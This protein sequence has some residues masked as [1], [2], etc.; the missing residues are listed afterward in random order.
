MITSSFYEMS[1]E[2]I[3]ECI[4]N[5]NSDGVDFIMEKYKNL[6]RQKARTLFLIGGDKDDLIQEGMIGLY[7]AVR[8]FD[9]SKESSFFH[10]ADLCIT[11]QLYNA[12]K[13]SL[14]QKNIP[15]N[16]Y[17]SIYTPLYKEFA[18]EE[19]STPLMETILPEQKLNPEEIVIDKENTDMI[20]YEL[21]KRLSQ[22]E[23]EVLGFYISGLNYQQIAKKLDK[24]PKSIDNAIQRIKSKLAQLLSSLQ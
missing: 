2:Q 24:S 4:K 13:A 5:G 20:E 16:T 22:F 14:R 8:D 21:G 12:V 18:E 6:V 19:D 9:A 23:N 17:V 7:K 3:L 1:D 11:R 10:F 15:L